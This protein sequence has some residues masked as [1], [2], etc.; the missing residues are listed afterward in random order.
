MMIFIVI[1]IVR[2][3]GLPAAPLL[4]GGIGTPGPELRNLV[5]WR[6]SSTLVNLTCFETDH[7]GS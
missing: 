2:K 5:N 4:T 7:L 3:G 6:L 1:V